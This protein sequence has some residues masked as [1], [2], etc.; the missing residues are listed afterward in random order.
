MN[1]SSSKNTL[2]IFSR[3]L[4]GAPSGVDP[5]VLLKDGIVAAVG[6]KALQG[7]ADEE[8]RLDSLWLSPAP[9]D[10]HVHLHFRGDPAEN[11]KVILK[12]GV[13]AVRDLGRHPRELAWHEEPSSLPLVRWAGVG[14]SATGP[15]RYW[16]SRGFSGPEQ[17]A[18]EAMRLTDAGVS[19]LKVFASGL[20]DFDRPGQ[21]RHPQ[22]VSREEIAAVVSVGRERGLPV[23]VHVNGDQGVGD[24]IR[25]GVDSI[26]HGYFMSPDTLA[27]LAQSGIAW[28][29]T[30]AAVAMHAIDPEG[31]HDAAT[32]ANLRQIVD[33]QK[34][35][36][37]LAEE[38]GVNLVMGSDSGSYALPHSRALYGEAGSWLDAGLK[39]ETVFAGCTKRAAKIMGYDGNLGEISEGALGILTALEQD[40]RINPLGLFRPAWRNY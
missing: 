29:P 31:R 18:T 3:G 4:A 22:V 21:V 8:L 30:L 24:C 32:L 37:C 7:P 16:L 38:L 17:F 25:A 11:R 34:E 6:E 33:S 1:P 40:P 23:A 35:N 9:L 26:E 2:R 13:A 14:M 20:L 39:P 28:C 12:A 5:V 10:A 15:G 36:L 19:V 27:E